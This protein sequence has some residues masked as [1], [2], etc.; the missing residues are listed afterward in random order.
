MAGQSKR[1]A[2]DRVI[3]DI[4]ALCTGDEM[5]KVRELSDPAALL[6]AA[7]GVGPE[8]RGIIERRIRG[9]LGFPGIGGYFQLRVLSV[10]LESAQDVVR[11][12]SSQMLRLSARG[13]AAEAHRKLQ[14]YRA[15]FVR[16]GGYFP[17]R[18]RAIRNDR[19]QGMYLDPAQREYI[20]EALVRTPTVRAISVMP[21]NLVDLGTRIVESGTRG[22]FNLQT[23]KT[24]TAA[25]YTTGH[26]RPRPGGGGGDLIPAS[27]R[28]APLPE[29]YTAAMLVAGILYDR[30]ELAYRFGGIEND[31]IRLQF[32]A[33]YELAQ[34][35]ADVTQLRHAG[36]AIAASRDSS[37]R[38]FRTETGL[39]EQF[40]GVWAEVID[41][42]VAFREI[43]ELAEAR[44]TDA[45][46]ARK[47]QYEAMSVPGFPASQPAGGLDTVSR[48]RLNTAAQSLSASG[49]ERQVSID[50]MRRLSESL[51]RPEDMPPQR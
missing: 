3:A 19:K 30:L 36:A 33:E 24:D 13:V 9:G 6:V 32:N 2:R 16:G 23:G 22:A 34:I 27:V 21:R 11:S 50:S 46:A 51:R 14:S 18:G 12:R 17:T 5:D 40:D 49:G 37:Q 15:D 45:L 29:M 25:Q 26:G 44:A 1:T 28:T 31:E 48:G 43:V 35:C 47:A 4:T 42:I 8:V 38:G 10:Q 20:F 39:G 7:G 41:R